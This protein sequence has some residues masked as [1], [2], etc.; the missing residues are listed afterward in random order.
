MPNGKLLP[1]WNGSARLGGMKELATRLTFYNGILNSFF[2]ASLYYDQNARIPVLDVPIQ[3]ILPTMGLFFLTLL[4]IAIALA[5][6]E[7]VVMV[8]SQMSYV[9]N[10]S[11]NEETSPLFREVRALRQDVE[12]LNERL[13]DDLDNEGDIR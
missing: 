6:W 2:V 8:R 12:E 4:L 11:E 13:D 10:Q 9:N 5:L 3:Q 7:H 1:Q